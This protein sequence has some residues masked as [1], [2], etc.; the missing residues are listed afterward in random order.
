MAATINLYETIGTGESNAAAVSKALKAAGP[1]APVELHINSG[2]GDAHQG[3][4]IYDILARHTGK[5]TCY[6]DGL[7]ASAA[8]FIAMAAQDIVMPE[9]AL[10]MVHYPRGTVEGKA[11]EVRKGAEAIDRLGRWMVSAYVKRTKQT[12]AAVEALMD[13]ETWMSAAE[14]VKL[15]FADRIEQSMAVT[16][17]ADVTT[18]GYRNV[19][20]DIGAYARGFWAKRGKAIPEVMVSPE[21]PTELEGVD[22]AAV[23][24]GWNRRGMR[25]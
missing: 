16:A 10:M 6:V 11:S 8:S 3:F 4:A 14:A 15:G 23:W 22:H 12:A 20:T 1:S 9:N 2:G 17:L 19:P 18:F 25:S 5:I 24:A 7:A 13:A 21:P